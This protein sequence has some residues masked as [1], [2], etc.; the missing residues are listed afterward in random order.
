MEDTGGDVLGQLLHAGEYKAI[1]ALVKSSDFDLL[2]SRV[3]QPLLNDLAHDTMQKDDN[4][5]VLMARGQYDFLKDLIE[6]SDRI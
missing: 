2:V 1:R 3:F 6:L 4:R 5:D